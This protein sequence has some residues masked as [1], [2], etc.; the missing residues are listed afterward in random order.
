MSTNGPA[1]SGPRRATIVLMISDGG[2]DTVAFPEDVLTEDEE[3]VLHLHPHW[4]VAVRP[5]LVLLFALVAVILAW[6]MLPDDT[7]GWIGV[8]VV[9]AVCG[10]LGLTRGLWPLLVWRCTH[11]VFTDE[12]I[13][14]QH[15]VVTRDRRDLP[16]SRVNDH[17]MSQS[18]L[19]R[20]FGT[21]T[22]T[23]DSIGERDPATLRDV[24]RVVRAQTALYELIEADSEREPAEDEEELT[25]G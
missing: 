1:E 15:G 14:L 23:I 5:A 4:R 22:L 11:Y 6:V 24:P 10:F 3:V 7:G 16:L 25:T 9:V 18:L 20:L 2:G 21:G 12:R 17:A 13:L 19:D 8:W